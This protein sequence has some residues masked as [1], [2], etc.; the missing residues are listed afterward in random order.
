[1]AIG[2]AA[3]VAIAIMQIVYILDSVAA[4]GTRE[5][6]T[7]SASEVG[8]KLSKILGYGNNCVAALGGPGF[9]YAYGGAAITFGAI[10]LPGSPQ[11]SLSTTAG[12][13]G[14]NV[15]GNM[16]VSNIVWKSSGALP[17]VVKTG[18]ITYNSFSGFLT[19]S[20][21]TTGGAATFAGGTLASLS[22]PITFLSNPA[23]ANTVEKCFP[24]FSAQDTCASGGGVPGGSGTDC[25]GSYFTQLSTSGVQ[26]CIGTCAPTPFPYV[27]S[28]NSQGVPQCACP[29]GGTYTP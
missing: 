29:F 2:F 7:L 9:Q 24:T 25:T 3:A 18:G 12:A 16:T 22:Y 8:I 10:T 4:A 14:H 20:F 6:V 1:M 27:A 19:I 15:F 21:S 13:P 17:N 26:N 5:K 28:F 11:A 23:N